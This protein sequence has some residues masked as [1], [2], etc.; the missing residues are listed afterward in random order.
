MFMVT[1]AIPYGIIRS[2]HIFPYGRKQEVKVE[3]RIQP[4]EWSPT[5]QNLSYHKQKL[6]EHGWCSSFKR[7]FHTMLME[8]IHRLYSRVWYTDIIKKGSIEKP[9]A[10]EERSKGQRKR[11]KYWWII[12]CDSGILTVRSTWTLEIALNRKHLELKLDILHWMAS[13]FA[14]STG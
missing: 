8:Q 11:W 14:K 9:D 1:E 10:V 3:R 6:G 13:Y 12:S 2:D 4:P 5:H 7:G